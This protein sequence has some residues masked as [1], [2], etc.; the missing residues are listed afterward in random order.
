MKFTI[1]DYEYHTML[2]DTGDD[3]LFIHIFIKAENRKTADTPFI[4]SYNELMKFIGTCDPSAYD[5][6]VKI[7]SGIRGYGPKQSEVLQVIQNESFDLEP[8]LLRYIQS[9]GDEFIEEF[10]QW[11]DRVIQPEAQKENQKIAESLHKT[12]EDSGMK[13][14]NIRHQHFQD[15]LDEAIHHVVVKNYPELFDN[16]DDDIQTYQSELI[17]VT[18][19]FSSTIDKILSGTHPRQNN[20]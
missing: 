5:Y 16:G 15:E 10:Y 19:D 13:E 14:Q 12:I 18:L 11:C 2:E 6:L 8:F 4:M 3:Y 9:K 7:R 1:A 20:I 17:R